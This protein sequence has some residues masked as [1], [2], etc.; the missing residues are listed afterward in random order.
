M[1]VFAVLRKRQV[2]AWPCEKERSILEQQSKLRTIFSKDYGTSQ[3][4]SKVTVN[5]G[6]YSTVHTQ[7]RL[8]HGKLRGN[9][10]LSV[11]KLRAIGGINSIH[12]DVN[13]RAAVIEVFK[14]QA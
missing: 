12:V 8:K 2:L 5:K 1:A 4:E 6:K 11:A 7:R 3:N 14:T 13:R 10:R 9:G